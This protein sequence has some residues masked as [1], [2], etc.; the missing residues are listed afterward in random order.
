MS[1]PSDDRL[2]RV[3]L[4]RLGEPGDPRLAALVDRARRRAVYDCAARRARPRRACATDVAARLR[5]ARPRRATSTQAARLGHPVRG[6]RRRRVA[7]A[8]STTSTGCRAA[9]RTAAARP[10]GLWVRGPLRLDELAT[11]RSRWSGSRSATTYGA[12]VAARDRGRDVA[13]AGCTVVSGAAFGIDQAAHRGALAA[14]G[15]TVAVLACG[16]DRAY[17]AAHRDLLDYIAD[18]GAGGLRAAARA[19]RRPGCGSCPA[20]G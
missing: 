1:A 11:A 8:G 18:D 12:G 6:P 15:P 7:R 14:G 17:P 10:L 2:A 5:R 3:A 13:R 20:T 9:A 19:A 4:C 16:V